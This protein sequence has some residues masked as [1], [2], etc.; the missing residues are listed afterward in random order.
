MTSKPA[1]KQVRERVEEIY[2]EESRRIFATLI[3]LLGD[4]GLAED[5]VQQL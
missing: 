4:F 3:R 1:E 5:A 2:R